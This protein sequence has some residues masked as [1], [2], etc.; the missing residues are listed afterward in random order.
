M[1]RTGSGDYWYAL[2]D[3]GIAV[4]DAIDED[5]PLSP[6]TLHLQRE[7]DEADRQETPSA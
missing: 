7:R 3:G 2:G 6:V 4:A 1:I 5:A